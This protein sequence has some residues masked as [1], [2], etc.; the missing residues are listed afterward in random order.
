MRN[1][2]KISMHIAIFIFIFLYAN[3]ISFSGTTKTIL[4]LLPASKTPSPTRFC[5][6]MRNI[7]AT[8]DPRALHRFLRI[9]HKL[10]ITLIAI[11]S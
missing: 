8:T 2:L 6:H 7:S 3:G 1:L 4:F 9:L 5:L 11:F 10:Q